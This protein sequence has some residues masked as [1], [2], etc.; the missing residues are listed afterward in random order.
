MAPTVTTNPQ[1]VTVH[2]GETATFKAA[3]SGTPAPSVQW[4]VSSNH[5][6]S[7]AADTADAGNKTDNLKVASVTLAESG[8]EYRAVFTNVVGSRTSSAATLTVQAA[9]AVTQ[10]PLSA[11]VTAG[12][13]ATFSAAASGSPTPTVQWQVSSNGGSSWAADTS[14]AGNISDTLTVASVTLAQSGNEYRAVFTNAAG[15]QPGSAATLTVQTRPVVTTN[16]VSVTRLEGETA[17]FTAG[18]E[19]TPTPSVQWQISTDQGTTWA[20]DTVDAGNTTDTLTVAAVTYAQSGYEYRG[21][22]RTPRAR[23]RANRRR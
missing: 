7:W 23:W 3:A 18:A 20:P 8:Y 5:G 14:D 11:T 17:T 4:E 6:S 19:A 12:E 10:N 21:C 15:S 1:N 2:A 22:S 16:P 9:P 13:T